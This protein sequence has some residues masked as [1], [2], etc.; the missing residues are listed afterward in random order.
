[1]T[2]KLIITT[3]AIIVLIGL[4]LGTKHF[5]A[6]AEPK[7]VKAKKT[8]LYTT[9]NTPFG[10]EFGK[11]DNPAQ[12][13]FKYQDTALH[14]QLPLP[15]EKIEWK[16][17]QGK[18]IAEMGNK[19]FSYSLLKNG[20]GKAAGIKEEIILKKPTN[21][22]QFEFSLNL[23]G[24]SARKEN[25]LWHF[26]NDK[27]KELFYIP[28]PFM[29][30]ANGERSENVKIE[31][32]GTPMKQT[33]TGDPNKIFVGSVGGSVL[34][35][36]VDRD[37]LLSP[38]R[39]YPISID[40]SLQLTILTV[41]SHPQTGEN[42]TVEFETE[43]KADLKIIPDDQATIDDDEFTGL[44][45]DEQKVNPQILE[46]DVI[47]YPN[48]QCAGI[49]KVIHY[50]KKTGKHTLRFEFGDQIAYAYN[51]IWIGADVKDR[52]DTTNPGSTVITLVSPSTGAGNLYQVKLYAYNAMYDVKVGTFSRS[53]AVFTSRDS[54]T[55]GYISSGG[56]KTYSGLTIEV[57]SGDYIGIYWSAGY[58][59]ATWTSNDSYLKGGDQFGQG[60]QTYTYESHRISLGGYVELNTAPTA[61]TSL[62]CEGQT[63]PT[64]ITDTTPEFSAIFND[65]NSG[66]TSNAYE[67]HVGTNSPDYNNMWDSGWV[68][69]STSEGARCSDKTYAGSALSTG[70]TYTWKIR[71]RDDDNAEGAWSSTATFKI[72]KACTLS[73]SSDAECCS[74]DCR[75]GHCYCAIKFEGVKM[76]G[77]K[78]E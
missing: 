16:T 64:D 12:I 72:C 33:E 61:P 27:G 57:Q 46:N 18:L 62:L 2:K 14:F 6:T 28:K 71:F 29:K 25:D 76:E 39:K 50:T 74:G 9:Q 26:Y 30:D 49:G 59:D 54:Y 23:E 4:V 11:K 68:S 52:P 65:P 44:Y 45:C 32:K 22:N 75:S 78:I 24:L 63:N 7:I 1:M 5:T 37:W 13:V 69:D 47:F 43:G 36:S 19:A 70:V 21:Q 53:G 10:A 41:H 55:I 35:V 67:I 42:W 8:S 56:L 34:S 58:L 66:D 60:A 20:E 17:E 15:A 3:L 31:I 48:W 77:V 38:E 40:P 51:A 73:C